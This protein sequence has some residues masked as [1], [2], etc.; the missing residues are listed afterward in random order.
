MPALVEFRTV[1]ELFT[2][3]VAHFR[4]S[5]KA[6]LTFKDRQSKEWIDITWDALH[7]RVLDLACYLYEMGIR[8]GDRVAI[9]SENR[10]EWAMVD[11]A[12]QMLGGVN[13]SLYT[14]LPAS[15]VEYIVRDS[16]SRI[17]FVSTS[18]QLRKAEDV[19]DAC[20]ELTEVITM[21]ELRAEHLAQVRQWDAVLA[22]GARLR[23]RHTDAVEKLASDVRADDL[24]ALIYTSGTT[25]EP[26]GV[27]LTHHNFASNVLSALGVVPFG[28]EDHHL[29]FLPLCHSF[30]RTGGY[31]AVLSCGARITYAESIDTV[32]RNLLEVRPTVMISVPVLFE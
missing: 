24:S 21:S 9:L 6:A 4:G 20:P 12:T 1:P 19:F 13:V 17:L 8:K 25:G 18:I 7:E 29:S 28:P 32:S 15:Q 11:L 31:L 30:E 2:N 14:S 26:K 5:D 3:L 23:S 22:E 10:P 27:M 16:G